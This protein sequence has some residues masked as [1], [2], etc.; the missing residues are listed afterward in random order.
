MGSYAPEMC[1]VTRTAMGF[2]MLAT[3]DW[4]LNVYFELSGLNLERKASPGCRGGHECCS[5]FPQ[6]QGLHPHSN[7]NS[8]KIK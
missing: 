4:K 6:R 8:A 3:C 2:L 1:K 5:L 7:I